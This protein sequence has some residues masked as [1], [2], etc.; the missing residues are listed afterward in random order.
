MASL[1]R[2][3]D[4]AALDAFEQKM[5]E[6][7]KLNDGAGMAAL[8]NDKQFEELRH[9]RAFDFS[10]RTVNE[11]FQE[12]RDKA[13]PERKPIQLT[14]DRYTAIRMCLKAAFDQLHLQ[15][16]YA[17]AMMRMSAV[18]NRRLMQRQESTDLLLADLNARIEALERKP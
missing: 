5:D 18:R 11:V 2:P 16:S 9:K 4:K 6:L 15:C 7:F 8:F 17:N 3:E 1:L 13:G 14:Q 12:L 10:E